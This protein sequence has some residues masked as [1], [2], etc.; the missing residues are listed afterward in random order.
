MK[1]NN[2]D[3]SRRILY[4]DNHLLIVNKLPSEIVQG[5]QT[6][7]RPM[8]EDLKDYLKEKYHKPGE[9]F[10]GVVHRLDRPVSGVVVFARTSK[11]LA[12]MNA[13]V[14]DRQMK[15]IYWA[16]VGKCPDPASGSLSHHLYRNQEQN[17]SYV[18]EHAVKDSRPA[19]LEYSLM[20]QSDRYFLLEINLITGRHHQ[21]RAQLAA[22]GSPVRGDL[23]YGYPR[24]NPD[25][26]IHLHAR[27]VSFDHPVSHKEILVEAAPP[28]DALWDH[29]Y[30][31]YH[32]SHEQ[33]R[34]SHH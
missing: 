23:K 15:K 5:D 3:I 33:Q 6:G 18:Y 31:L 21:I 19:L 27:S 17:R 20:F 2:T 9:V 13:L 10:L 16:V 25:G 14:R 4:E 26:S 8:S 30:H 24:S 7:D 28:E 1:G 32:E 22:T 11:G 12:R 34:K 29:F